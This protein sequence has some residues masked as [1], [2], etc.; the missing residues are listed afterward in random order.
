MSLLQ[1]DQNG[2]LLIGF[3]LAGFLLQTFDSIIKFDLALE[4]LFYDVI[5]IDKV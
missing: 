1:S 4:D 5:Y 2:L 3:L